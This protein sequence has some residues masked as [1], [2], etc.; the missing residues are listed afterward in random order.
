MK[1]YIPVAIMFGQH[2]FTLYSIIPCGNYKA[3][4]VPTHLNRGG[5]YLCKFYAGLRC[6]AMRAE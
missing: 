3:V 6:T 5:Y 1:A 4:C 2:F